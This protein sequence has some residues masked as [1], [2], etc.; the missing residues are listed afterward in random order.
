MARRN[1]MRDLTAEELVVELHP[2]NE[3]S[4]SHTRAAA[5]EISE[6]V[7]YLNHATQNPEALP[8]PGAAAEMLHLI[9]QTVRRLP[10]LV[11]QAGLEGELADRLDG[12]GREIEQAAF[13]VKQTGD[14]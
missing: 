5:A 8:G 13:A 10:Q 1:R 9:G 3:W 11:K 14:G 2:Y 4:F 7:R 12:L 6:L